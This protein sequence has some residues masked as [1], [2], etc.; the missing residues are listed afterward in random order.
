[1]AMEEGIVHI[2]RGRARSIDLLGSEFETWQQA[3][4]EAMAAR[5]VEDWVRACLDENALTLRSCQAVRR[6]ALAGQVGDLQGVG[7]ATAKVFDS[8]TRLFDLVLT[9]VQKAEARGFTIEQA[10]ELRQAAT[11]LRRRRAE[12]VAF[13]PWLDEALWRRAGEDMDADRVEDAEDILH[14]LQSR[15]PGGH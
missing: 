13:W 12:F 9:G 14:E 15:H 8:A 7:E 4:V 1:M 10:P 3:H 11:E 5:D 2:C 6:K